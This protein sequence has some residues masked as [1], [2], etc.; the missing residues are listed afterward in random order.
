MYH[1]IICH[2]CSYMNQHRQLLLT[3]ISFPV[4]ASQTLSDISAEPVTTYWESCEKWIHVIRSTCEIFWMQNP[5]CTR[6]TFT[7][8]VTINNLIDTPYNIL[9]NY[10]YFCNIFRITHRT[11]RPTRCSPTL[12]DGPSCVWYQILFHIR[13]NPP[14]LTLVSYLAL[15]CHIIPSPSSLFS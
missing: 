2:I 12:W 11:N 5:S 10:I 4:P 8:N 13:Y 7:L 9:Y 14:P 6:H 1:N 15:I 3:C